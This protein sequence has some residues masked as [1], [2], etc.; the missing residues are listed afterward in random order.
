MLAEALYDKGPGY[1]EGW[2]FGPR[3]LQALPVR[4]IVELMGSLWGE[5]ARWVLEDQPQVHEAAL[6]RLDWS[7]AAKELQWLPV[8]SIEE[9]LKFTV[10]WYSAWRQEKD[11]RDF[12]LH[13]IEEYEHLAGR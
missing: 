5:D 11:M 3:D 10:S 1:G 13:Q 12:T 4:K 2:N 6:L 7:K 8:F 9:A